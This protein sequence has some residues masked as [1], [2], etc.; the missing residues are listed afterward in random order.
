MMRFTLCALFAA[1]LLAGCASQ[2]PPDVTTYVN[3]GTGTRTDLL[4]ENMLET[5]DKTPEVVWLNAARAFL[6][7]GKAKCYLE[8]DYLSSEEHG[9]LNI[10]PGETLSLTID[11]NLSKYVGMGSAKLRRKTKNATVTERAIYEVDSSLI[12][13]LAAAKKVHVQVTG[14]NGTVDRWFT[15][16]SFRRFGDFA[17][18]I[19]P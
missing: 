19:A 17:K 9:F 5:E 3:Q 1:V 16:E 15:A 10:P 4:S 14:D 8:L 7:N 6:W 13:Q 18:K 11:G 12:A 2:P